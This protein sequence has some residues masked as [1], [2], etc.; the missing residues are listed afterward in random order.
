MVHLGGT[1]HMIF[2]VTHDANGGLHIATHVNTAGLSGIGLT[3]GNTYHAS[4]A[5]SFVSNSAGSGN[6][7]T[8]INNFLMTAPGVGNNVRVHELLHG[9]IDT[10]GNVIAVIEK[11]TSD[12]G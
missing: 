10:N 2:A 1:A 12:C 9:Y 4:Q 3:T 5:D 8:F 6:E 11:I 7:F